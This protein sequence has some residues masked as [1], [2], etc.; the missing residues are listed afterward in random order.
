MIEIRNQNNPE[1][2]KVYQIRLKG[3]LGSQWSNWFD[4]LSISLEENGDTLLTGSVADQA[5]LYGLLRRVRDAGLPLLSVTCLEQTDV[6][7]I[8]R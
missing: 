4:G 8:I 1:Q 6:P 2:P 5:A 7:D 3:H